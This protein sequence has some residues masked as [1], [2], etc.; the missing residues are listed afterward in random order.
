MTRQRAPNNTLGQ[1]KPDRGLISSDLIAGLT[2]SVVNVPQA[3]AHAL[4]A[5]VSN[6]VMGIY[7]LMVAVPVGAVFTS[8]VL[9]NV[10]TTGALS[11]ATGE[12]LGPLPVA[13]RTA[14]LV[15]LVFLVGLFQILA[16]VFRLGFLVRFVSNAVM[17][18]F[19]NGIAVLIIV[20]QLGALTGYFSPYSNRIAQALDLF[21]HL[22]QVN[23]YTTVIGLLTLGL[24][25]LLLSS[26]LRKFAFI[27]AIALATVLVTALG[28]Q[29]VETV[30]DIAT[31]TAKLP[32]IAV[33]D[34]ALLLQ[35][36]LPAFSIA[37]IG[38]I[39]GAGVS[40]G[41]PNPDGKYPNISRDFLGQGIANLATSFVGGIPAGGSISGTALIMSAGARSRWTNISVGVFVAL[42]VALFASLVSLVPMSALAALLIVAGFQGL[43]V[44]QALTVWNTSRVSGVVMILTFLAT[45]VMPLQY[46][47]LVGVAFSIL[48]YVARQSNRVVLIQI[49]PVPGGLP[50]EHPAPE[51]LPSNKVT[52]LQIYG[53]L[54]FAAAKS[55]EE[56][57]PAVD[58]TTHAVVLIG[59]RGRNEIGSTFVNVL[60][61]YSKDLQ[62]HNSKLMLVGVSPEVY[63]QL[64]RSGLRAQIGDENIFP[65]TAQLGAAMNRAL[66]VA[67]QWLDQPAEVAFDPGNL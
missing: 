29:S 44:P 30:G 9:M 53:S 12:V 55:L 17:T 6:P 38:L 25:A 8:S 19:L 26:R 14:A 50:E 63:S 48:L 51:S 65:A 18:G 10:S 7:T 64:A 4:L 20:G 41:Y 27:I 13:S 16:G 31:I 43:R 35:M 23:R 52:M 1:L 66:V 57:L 2:F 46:A 56:L 62:A 39:Q 11:V 61:R 40:Q 59:L 3:M 34:V 45:L 24:M 37:I 5:L 15:A 36:L 67:N 54:F 32:E 28:W 22:D 47:V 21:L 60:E 42:I 58:D 49:V 33:P